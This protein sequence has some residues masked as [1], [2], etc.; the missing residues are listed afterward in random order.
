MSSLWPHQLEGVRRIQRQASLMLAFEMGCGKT[1]TAI[2]GMRACDA[3]SVLVLCPKKVIS[4]WPDE[5]EKWAQGCYEVAP[6][7]SG[8][9]KRKASA[10]PTCGAPHVV[11]VNYDSAW[12]GELGKALLARDWDMVIADES[13][14]AK[15]ST[16]QIGKWIA[17]LKA[18]R[19][20]ALTGTPMPH[21]PLDVFGQ[22]KFLDPSVFGKS[23]TAF[24]A[25][26]AV[27]RPLPNS[28]AQMIVGYQ[29][30]DDLER[31]I[32][33]QIM[34]VT[35]DEVLELPETLDVWRWVDLE[36]K[37]RKLYDQLERESIADLGDD[38]LVAD[39]VLVKLL[40]LQQVC[41]G[42]VTTEG[43]DTVEVSTAKRDA[44]AE[45][46]DDI[47]A[48]EPVVVFGQFKADIAA[49][50]AASGARRYF[51][52]S[53]AANELRNW[54]DDDSGAVIGV[55]IQAGGIGVD[56]TRARYCVYMSTGFNMG[57]YLQ[58]R[59]RVHRP[60]QE[61]KVVYYHFGAARTVDAH[62]AKALKKR[63]DL[64]TCVLE[65]VRH[66]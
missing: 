59:A 17:K 66:G 26:Y 34:R 50:R 61:R 10:V 4:V 41:S 30:I 28:R 46:L 33:P 27:Q 16:T 36:P 53:G 35:A 37:A 45:L 5:I 65:R 13:H 7:T 19:R 60:G 58:S 44:L 20:V 21:S 22:W 42:A 64:V 31:R 43:G 56:M 52:L 12:R 11:V 15:S 54:Q 62:V 39:N 32:A 1:R 57:A 14:R 29:N 25:R 47:P 55:Q 63:E 49:V 24:K 51:E 48:H 2:E 8:T 9:A 6:L 38:A 3:R 18:H 23:W 40:R